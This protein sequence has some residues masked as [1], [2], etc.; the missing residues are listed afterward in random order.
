[1]VIPYEQADINML[2]DKEKEEI[3]EIENLF[4]M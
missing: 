2:Y 4:V 3:K 1:M